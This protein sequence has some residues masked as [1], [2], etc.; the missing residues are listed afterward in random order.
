M[1]KMVMTCSHYRIELAYFRWLP[2]LIFRRKTIQIGNYKALKQA[3]EAI[4]GSTANLQSIIQKHEIWITSL[5]K[6]WSSENHYLTTI[7]RVVPSTRLIGSE[8]LA[9]FL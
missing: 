2:F 3:F 8:N 9:F 4:Q 6:T 5:G 1:K 7:Y